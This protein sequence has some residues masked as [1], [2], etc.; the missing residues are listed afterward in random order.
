MHTIQKPSQKALRKVR[1]QMVLQ[2][3]DLK[4]PVLVL[5]PRDNQN[6]NRQLQELGLGFN[7]QLQELGL[8]LGLS[9]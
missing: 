1:Q 7:R 9:E 8:G 5:V 2:N 3:M 6:F 4:N